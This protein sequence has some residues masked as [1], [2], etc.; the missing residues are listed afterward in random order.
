MSEKKRQNQINAKQSIN[1]DA[2]PFKIHIIAKIKHYISY[3]EKVIFKFHNSQHIHKTIIDFL[4]FQT[5]LAQNIQSSNNTFL[6]MNLKLCELVTMV[7]LY[8]I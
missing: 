2:M 6:S 3:V 1:S 8:S 4:I 5:K 7:S